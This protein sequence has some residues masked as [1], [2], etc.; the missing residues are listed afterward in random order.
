[1]PALARS[2]GTR[3]T[4]LHVPPPTARPVVLAAGA[5]SAT[6]YLG[7]AVD[8]LISFI[9]RA[10]PLLSPAWL[11]AP[12]APTS[13]SPADAPA[14]AATVPT[15]AG[16]GGSRGLRI[17]RLLSAQA[18]AS[19]CAPRRALS[20]RRHADRLLSAPRPRRIEQVAVDLLLELVLD[21]SSTPSLSAA[22]AAAL[23]RAH[24]AAAVALGA[25]LHGRFGASL[26]NLIEY[27]GRQLALPLASRVGGMLSDGTLLV[28]AAD[29]A[30]S[31]SLAKRC[32]A[33]P[34]V[35]VCGVLAPR[36]GVSSCP[37]P[38]A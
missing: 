9:A 6:P 18:R 27:E 34:R 33:T 2:R 25:A 37:W 31:I 4:A 7:E 23:T 21:S 8:A 10:P 5:G 20:C 13:G 29:L 15:T 19:A 36:G 24:D 30:K 22:H 1:M 35:G 26:C 17:G 11:G 12:A 16:P 14:P 38:G 28:P 3:C 32:V